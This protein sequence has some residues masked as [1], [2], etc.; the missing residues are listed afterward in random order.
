MRDAPRKK[1]D[2]DA[3]TEHMRSLGAGEISDRVGAS[4]PD[5]T[6]S[7]TGQAVIVAIYAMKICECNPDD[8]A[9]IVEM[10]QENARLVQ[11]LREISYKSTKRHKSIREQEICLMRA[12]E[13]IAVLKKK[14]GE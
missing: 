12:R 13:E 14:G 3:D 11:R 9:R 10:E 7:E 1:V 5:H 8:I 6:L 4:S 2:S